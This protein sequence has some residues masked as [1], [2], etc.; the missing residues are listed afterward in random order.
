MIKISL[1]RDRDK[2][3][4]VTGIH[5]T[6]GCVC[7]SYCYCDCR[8]KCKYKNGF[9]FHNWSIEV[10][11]F[12]EYNLHIKLPNLLY[13]SKEYIDLSGTEKCPFHRSRRYTCADCKYQLGLR[14]CSIPFYERKEIKEPTEWGEHYL[15]G[16]FEKCDWADNL[17]KDTGKMI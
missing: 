12:F 4:R 5:I 2:G 6:Y 16:S 11:R 1:I 8:N 14:N 7:N 3:N 13:I 10:R 15:C 9:N 17:D